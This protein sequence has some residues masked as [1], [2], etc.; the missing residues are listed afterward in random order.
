MRSLF[1]L[2]TPIALFFVFTPVEIAVPAAAESVVKSS[3]D[4][5]LMRPIL[6]SCVSVNLP[7]LARTAEEI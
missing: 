3:A 6:L 5:V 7:P 2:S 4:C 1:E